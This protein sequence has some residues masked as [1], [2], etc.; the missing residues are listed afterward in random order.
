M[1]NELTKEQED[2]M[3][4]VAQEWKDRFFNTKRINEK[5]FE[6]GI[7]WL[8][9]DL[10]K[11]DMPT[12]IYCES[13][14]GALIAID[15]LKNKGASVRSSVGDSVGS[16]VRSSVG[17]SVRSSVRSSVGDSVWDSVWASVRASVW[18]SVWASVGASVSDSVV[19]SVGASVWASVSDSVGDSV[20]AYSS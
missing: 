8:Y 9:C 17:D 1:L 15:L 16:S 11:K 10:L 6:D 18:D 13:W 12:V 2:L 7:K 20:R 5:Q 4:V 19:A 3:S 14:L